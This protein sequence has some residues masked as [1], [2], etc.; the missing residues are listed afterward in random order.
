M[1]AFGV[2]PKDVGLLPGR[3]PYRGTIVQREKCKTRSFTTVTS[4]AIRALESG[5]SAATLTGGGCSASLR[6]SDI[7]YGIEGTTGAAQPIRLT[8]DV[9]Y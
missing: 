4:C 8:G 6:Q 3:A 5:R 9:E 1:N 7:H 2:G